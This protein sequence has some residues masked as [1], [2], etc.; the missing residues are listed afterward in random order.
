VGIEVDRA[1]DGQ[2]Q[3]GVAG[4]R[5]FERSV[6]VTNRPYG[7]M[8]A[9]RETRSGPDANIIQNL[10]YRP[11][12]RYCIGRTNPHAGQAIHTLV[13]ADLESQRLSA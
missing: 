9:L 8:R 4:L 6:E 2:D 13:S 10:D 1:F 5:Q 7:I 11:F 3:Y 12:D